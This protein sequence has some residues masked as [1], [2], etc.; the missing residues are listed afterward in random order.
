MQAIKLFFAIGRASRPKWRAFRLFHRLQEIIANISGLK[1][2]STCINLLSKSLKLKGGG[3]ESWTGTNGG[4]ATQELLGYKN[5]EH[6]KHL[7]EHHC[8]ARIHLNQLY[9]FA[10]NYILWEEHCYTP[11]K[12]SV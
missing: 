7:P 1:S 10:S 4:S 5:R 3:G 11:S 8:T 6:G 9:V 12:Q 2:S